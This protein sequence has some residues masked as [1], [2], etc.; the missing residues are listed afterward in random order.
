MD[1]Y[2]FVI[3]RYELISFSVGAAMQEEISWNG[4][5]ETAVMD[6]TRAKSIKN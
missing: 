3:M 4:T 6:G 2:S 5:I 1:V